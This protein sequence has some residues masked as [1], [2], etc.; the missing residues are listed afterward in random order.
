[1]RTEPPSPTD[2][3]RGKDDE[4][5]RTNA[6]TERIIGCA[7]EVHRVVGAGAFGAGLRECIVPGIRC[8]G[9]TVSTASIVSTSFDQGYSAFD[10]LDSLLRELCFSVAKRFSYA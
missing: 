8:R 4:L 5:R 1:M 9:T 3:N 6:I 2:A 10:S 7:I